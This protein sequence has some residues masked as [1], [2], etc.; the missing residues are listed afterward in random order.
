[1]L[2][3]GTN[4]FPGGSDSRC[5]PSPFHGAPDLPTY[6]DLTSDGLHAL[7]PSDILPSINGLV[8]PEDKRSHP[9]SQ[10]GWQKRLS[11]SLAYASLVCSLSFWLVAALYYVQSGLHVRIP[12]WRWVNSIANWQRVLFEAFALLLAMVATALVGFFG[13]KLWRIALPVAFLTFL[14]TYY[15]MVS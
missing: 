10:G 1:M 8:I 4:Q 11:S 5:E 2:P 6:R 7:T 3:G 12:G 13:A 15:T 14:L 9:D